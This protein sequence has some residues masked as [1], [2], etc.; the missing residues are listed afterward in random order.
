MAQQYPQQWLE[1]EEQPAASEWN[2]PERR[3][4]H[5]V[6]M[7]S[8][9]IEQVL[10]NHEVPAGVSGGSIRP[11]W[12]SFDLASQLSGGWDKLRRL[13]GD[14]TGEL[15]T[16]LGVPEVR[17]LRQNGTLRLAIMRNDPH[18]VDLLDLLDLLPECGGLS[19][20]LGLDHQGQPVILDLEQ[21]DL[22]NVLVAGVSGAGKSSLMRSIAVS[23]ALTCRQS[24]AQMAVIGLGSAPSGITTRPNPLYPVNYLPH[25]L[26]PVATEVEEAIEA[27]AYLQEEVAYRADNNI[28]SPALIIL[29]DDADMFL[30]RVG[31]S[32]ASQ[33][34]A[35]L[36]APA[37]A[38]VRV[39]VGA[40][41]PSLPDLWQMLQHNV[42]LRLVGRMADERAAQAATGLEKSYAQYL[43]GKGDFIAVATAGITPFQA[44]Y[45]DDYDLHLTLTELHRASSPVLLAQSFDDEPALPPSKNVSD[46]RR[47][48]YDGEEDGLEFQPDDGPQL[49]TIEIA[50][51]P[52]DAAE[53][54]GE[55]LSWIDATS[56]NGLPGGLSLPLYDEEPEAGPQTP[57]GQDDSP[58]DF[59]NLSPKAEV[60]TVTGD[61]RPLDRGAL[62]PGASRSMQPAAGSPS[63]LMDPDVLEEPDSEEVEPDEI[64]DQDEDG[65]EM[66]PFDDGPP[67]DAPEA[68]P[69]AATRMQTS[70]APQVDGQ[71][72][73]GR[74]PGAGRHVGQVDTGRAQKL[75]P[76][77][78]VY[79]DI[80][81]DLWDASEADDD[82]RK[83]LH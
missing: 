70:E 57:A 38:G 80:D 72:M 66:L 34:A 55:K 44:A 22:H 14:L 51:D 68:A 17:L 31:G 48:T 23:L 16:A 32:V 36:H 43:D 19:T 8:R 73:S 30:R 63:P 56:S 46:D 60:A 21:V 29:I 25:L 9:Q 10:A 3:L 15:A 83:R 35:L 49:R 12:V 18:P 61:E 7:Q 1:S 58:V 71:P 65:Y 62:G 27:L 82:W 28:N 78:P 4:Q 20:A 2:N 24:Q 64:A 33:L 39:I 52:F 75:W 76:V 13:T 74:Q 42:D 53:P 40:S 5:Q 6:E 59:D 54:A 67:D 47:F 41:N 79:T 50:V 37:G 77:E 81:D 45:I 69:D 26:F 11:H